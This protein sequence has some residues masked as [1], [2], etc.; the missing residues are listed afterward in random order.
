MMGRIES[1]LA[2]PSAA[3]VGLCISRLW[4]LI[5]LLVRDNFHAYHCLHRRHLSV[6][7][8]PLLHAR[9][10]VQGLFVQLRSVAA[11]LVMHVGWT[12]LMVMM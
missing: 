9:T 7:G 11:W 4:V 6:D 2:A 8:R 12:M 10:E 5:S 1:E 3:S